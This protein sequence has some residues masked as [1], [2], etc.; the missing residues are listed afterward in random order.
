M[1]EAM[2]PAPNTL[3]RVASV[4]LRLLDAAAD[5]TP[6]DGPVEL[7]DRLQAVAQEIFEIQE[8]IRLLVHVTELEESEF[9]STLTEIDDR[10]GE[11]WQPESSP[12][13]DVVKRLR[14]ECGSRGY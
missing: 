11:G 10:L 14:E 5:L 7:H 6:I 12:V 8:A 9:L 1:S 2:Q 13:A 3:E 4:R